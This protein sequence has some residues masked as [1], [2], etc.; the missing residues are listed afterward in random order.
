MPNEELISVLRSVIREELDPIVKR[1]DNLEGQVQENTAFIKAL[2]HQTEELD[3]KFDGLLHTT[4]TKDAIA[5]LDAKFEVLNSRL[6]NQEADIQ[7]L[8]AVK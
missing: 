5:R 1:L 4:A 8:K 6:F 2:L 7:L 3:A